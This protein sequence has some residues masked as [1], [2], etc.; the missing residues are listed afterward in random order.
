MFRKQLLALATIAGLILLN[1]W[2]FDA[3]FNTN[4]LLWYIQ[5]G[6]FISF[7]ITFI[8]FVSQNFNKDVDTVSADPLT[9]L[10][11]YLRHLALPLGVMGIRMRANAGVSEIA[12]DNNSN[13]SEQGQTA[14]DQST[15]SNEERSRLAQFLDS[16]LFLL[17]APII[18]LTP[19]LWIVIVIPPQYFV[20]LICGAPARYIHPK[21]Y[22]AV[23][24]NE[25]GKL[26][27]DYI[28]YA[29]ENAEDRQDVSLGIEPFPLTNLLSILFFEAVKF[30]VL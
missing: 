16:L 1:R 29:K 23:T 15:S 8:S 5:N 21:D 2:I 9:Y 10:A 3:L 7:G 13:I 14:I 11:T 30:L 24:K 17:W 18:L 28:K 19:L 12:Q 22:R 25:N 26:T 20:F 4:Y 6:S 27:L